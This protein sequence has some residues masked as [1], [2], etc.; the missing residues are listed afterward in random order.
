[1]IDLAPNQ[2]EYVVAMLQR[3]FPHEEVW[4]F[5]SRIRSTA[6]P[7]S[8]LDLAVVGETKLPFA[9]FLDALNAIEESELP[10]RVDLLDYHRVKP[11]FQA[12]LQQEHVVIKPG[13]MPMGG[14]QAP[15]Q[16]A[17][18]SER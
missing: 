8:D 3:L 12:I 10:F 18:D 2:L 17:E 16:A 5:G 14:K 1:M 4:A 9:R 6:K 11:S 13:G 15:M 7:Y